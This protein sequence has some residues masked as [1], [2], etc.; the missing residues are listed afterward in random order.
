MHNFCTGQQQGREQELHTGQG[1]AQE[2]ANSDGSAG[3]KKG[4]SL[5]PLSLS[6]VYLLAME[7]L[8]SI[9]SLHFLSLLILSSTEDDDGIL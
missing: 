8:Y 2:H 5:T 6:L 1:Q 3:G 7:L 9:S 4:M